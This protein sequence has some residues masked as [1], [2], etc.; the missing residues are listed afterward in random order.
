MPLPTP[1]ENESKEDF[2]KRFM[3]SNVAI[4]EFP[5]VNQRYAVAIDKWKNK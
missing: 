3:E 5:D 2:I 1:K 4:S